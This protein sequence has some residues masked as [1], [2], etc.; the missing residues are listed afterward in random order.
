MQ[1]FSIALSLG[2]LLLAQSSFAADTQ[3]GA[4]L[5]ARC[6]ACHGQHGVSNNPLY[7][8]L[9]GQKKEYL[10]KQLRDFASGKRT[11]PVMSAMVKGLSEQDMQN[12]ASYFNRQKP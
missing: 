8:N 2:L 12:L 7:P 11:D 5:A 10:G 6:S 4:Q 3:A 1:S 9:A